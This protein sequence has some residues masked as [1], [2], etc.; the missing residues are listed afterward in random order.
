MLIFGRNLA[1]P[2]G[3]ADDF[4]DR[5]EQD[6][7]RRRELIDRMKDER[8]ESMRTT[9]ELVEKV[10]AL[11]ARV[12]QNAR[13]EHPDGAGSKKLSENVGSP[14]CPECGNSDFRVAVG[15]QTGEVKLKCADCDETH[16]KLP[17]TEDPTES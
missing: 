2:A 1:T 9:D 14:F 10:S 7:K 16:R 8:T 4:L 6:L 15:S 3:V 5:I 12:A 17:P 13:L 11:N